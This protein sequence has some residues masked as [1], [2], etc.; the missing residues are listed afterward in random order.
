MM[1]KG[2]LLTDESS[3][4]HFCRG[5]F[6]LVT[7]SQFLII[8]LKV[9]LTCSTSLMKIKALGRQIKRPGTLLIKALTSRQKILSWRDA[10]GGHVSCFRAT[11]ANLL[12]YL[13]RV[14]KSTKLELGFWLWSHFSEYKNAQGVSL[15][16]QRGFLLLP[17]Q[18]FDFWTGCA[19]HNASKI[20]EVF[21]TTFSEWGSGI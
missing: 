7:F 11:S 17:A 3:S 4:W 19:L 9:F 10:H 8:T 6:L 15:P 5:S 18:F 16:S 21:G 13:R 1:V 2:W 12:K 20:N 14:R